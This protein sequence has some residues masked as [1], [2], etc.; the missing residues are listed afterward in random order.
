MRKCLLICLLVLCASGCVDDRIKRASS[1]TRTKAEVAK[2]EFEAAK[3]PEE[4][5][6][7]AEN[8]FNSAP[9]MLSA[10]DDYLWG[11]P[12]TPEPV[13]AP[14]PAPTPTP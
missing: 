8:W 2:K 14:T 5:I 4:K 7:I 10:I 1:L 12:P 9:K 6:A 3:T 11:R 13:P